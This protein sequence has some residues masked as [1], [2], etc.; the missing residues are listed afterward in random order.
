MHALFTVS[1]RF[2]ETKNLLVLS[3]DVVI[4]SAMDRSAL[5]CAPREGRCAC[6]N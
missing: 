3:P 2:T 1:Q 6:R 4:E 5:L